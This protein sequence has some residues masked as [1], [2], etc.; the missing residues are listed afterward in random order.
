MKIKKLYVGK[1][2]EFQK[3]SGLFNSSYRKKEVK[4]KIFVNFLGLKNDNQSDKKSHGGKDRAVCVYNQSSYDFFKVKY[5]LSLQECMF[6]ENITLLECSDDDICLGDIYSCG[7]ALFEVCQPRLPCWKISFITGIKNLTS[8]VVKES[9]TGFQLRVLREGEISFNDDFSLIERKNPNISISY[10][11]RCYF[12]A[13]NNQE[14]IKIILKIPQ[15]ADAYRIA[16][17][18]RYINKE[19]GIEVFQKDKE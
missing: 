19:E 4:D 8:L 2:E 9:K 17:E 12:D 14:K 3:K 11:N 5:N 16:L 18:K 10:I 1:E 13:K 15:L 6:G 7:D